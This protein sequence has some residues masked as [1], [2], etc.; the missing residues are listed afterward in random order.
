M[1]IAYGEGPQVEFKCVV[2][3]TQ[4][5]DD[6]H[7]KICRTVAPFANEVGGHIIFGVADDGAVVGVDTAS[8]TLQELRDDVTRFIADMVDPLPTFRVDC[9][10]LSD[11]PL[12]VVRVEKG[13]HTPYGVDKVKPTFYVRRG[14]TTFPASVQQVHSL[15]QGN[16]SSVATSAQNW[17]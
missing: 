1:L 11:K 17:N 13:P 2:K 5:D 3:G 14:A 7:R 16:V 6:Y 10:T 4:R 9:I 8:R 15:A 12:L